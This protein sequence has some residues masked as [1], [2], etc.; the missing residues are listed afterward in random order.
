MPHRHH[1]QN[2]PQLPTRSLSSIVHLVCFP[3]PSPL[4]TPI[5]WHSL[6]IVVFKS[7]SWF[8]KNGGW[9]PYYLQIRLSFQILPKFD[10]F[11]Y[12]CVHNY[13]NHSSSCALQVRKFQS[14]ENIFHQESLEL[15]FSACTLHQHSQA[16]CD[17]FCKYQQSPETHYLLMKFSSIQNAYRVSS[18]LN[19]P[20]VRG[21][22][23][24][25]CN[26]KTIIWRVT[27]NFCV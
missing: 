5:H 19:R 10:I 1:L 13:P 27:I 8:W 6:K 11:I 12:D 18:T 17:C 22:T 4:S 16:D 14:S 26:W 2:K 25:F 9:Q 3:V 20:P 7:S 15:P 21:Q 24:S 23:S